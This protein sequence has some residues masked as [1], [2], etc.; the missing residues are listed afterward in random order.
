MNLTVRA[1]GTWQHTLDIEIPVEEVE[2]R[3]GEVARQLQRRAS[4]PGFRKGRVPLEMVRQHYAEAVEQEFL[5][6]NEQEQSVR[7]V[8]AKMESGFISRLA[9]FQHE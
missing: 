3:L 9:E 1:T 6:L 4:L 2:R 5:N 8:M 7:A